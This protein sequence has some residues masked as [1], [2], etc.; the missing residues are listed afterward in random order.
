MEET[1]TRSNTYTEQPTHVAT[2]DIHIHTEGYE[3][4][5][6]M[7]TEKTYCDGVRNACLGA[8]R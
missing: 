5:G 8:G 2:S 6:D 1:Y 4:G 3:H 7:H